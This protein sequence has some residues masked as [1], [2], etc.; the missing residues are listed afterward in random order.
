M[1][2][3]PYS[4]SQRLLFGFLAL[5]RHKMFSV[6]FSDLDPGWLELLRGRVGL[7]STSKTS[8]LSG[9]DLFITDLQH[10]KS[11]DLQPVRGGLKRG[12]R[13]VP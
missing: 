13:K 9:P 4:W 12:F 7:S 10:V 2:S 8:V 3:G 1:F 5:N 11:R 6:L